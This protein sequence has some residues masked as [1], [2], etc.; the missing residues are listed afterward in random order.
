V[1]TTV[2]VHVPLSSPEKP[3]SVNVSLRSS[4][5]AL[6]AEDRDGRRAVRQRDDEVTAIRVRDVGRE[7]H[8]LE[9]AGIRDLDRVRHAGRRVVR[10]RGARHRRVAVRLATRGR[11]I[12][13]R[14]RRNF[15]D[16]RRAVLLDVPHREPAVARAVRMVDAERGGA[17]RVLEQPEA[18]LLLGLAVRVEDRT[19]AIAHMD[20]VPAEITLSLEFFAKR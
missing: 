10:D 6:A 2:S 16:D 12:V 18:L 3:A 4:A 8:A 14:Q 11:R 17:P 5:D 15:R 13:R 7:L 20:A 9:R 19:A 1:S